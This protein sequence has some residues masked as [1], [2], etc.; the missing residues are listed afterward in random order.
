MKRSRV[1]VAALVVLGLGACACAGGLRHR[2]AQRS[3]AS[4]P[5][6]A[7]S[8]AVTSLGVSLPVVSSPYDDP[9]LA[10]ARAKERARDY[11]GALAIVSAARKANPADPRAACAFAYLEGRLAV[12]AEHHDAALAAFDAVIAG[13]VPTDGGRSSCGLAAYARLR[14]AQSAAKLG[15]WDVVLDRLSKVPEDFPLASERLVGEAEARAAKGDRAGAAALWRRMLAA[16]SFGPRWVDTSAKLAT[17]LLDGVLGDPKAEAKEAYELATRIVVSAPKFDAAQGATALRARAAALLQNA[18]FSAA[19]TVEESAKQVQSWLDAGEATRAA[20]AANEA[21]AKVPAPVPCKLALVRA[22]AIARTKQSS[23]AAWGEAITA[24]DGQPEQA[25]AF[26]GGGKA[27]SGKRPDEARARFAK[28]E[29]RFPKNRLADDARLFGAV[30]ARDAGDVERFASMLLAL[31]DDYPDGDMRAEAL[32]KVALERLRTG[33]ARGAVA[34]LERTLTLGL[35][36]RHASVARATYFL[37]RARAELGDVAGARERYVTVVREQPLSFFMLLAY[38]RLAEVNADDAARVL[39]EAMTQGRDEPRRTARDLDEGGMARAARLMEVGEID[40]A[41][42]EVARAGLK[43][44]GELSALVGQLFEKVGAFDAGVALAR[45]ADLLS[46][47]PNE[48]WRS[49]WEAAYPRAHE[50]L[51]RPEAAKNGI[52]VSLAWGIMR[53]ESAFAVEVK[54]SANAYGLMQLIVPTAKLVA[55]G[56]GLPFD[57]AGLKRADVNVTLGTKLLGQL[58]VSLGDARVLAP[59]AYNAGAGALGRW[60]DARKGEPFDLFVEEIPYEETRNY[61][62]KVLSSQAVYAMLYDRS[63]LEETLRLPAKAP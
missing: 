25:T 3:A 37:G 56:T 22:Q 21:V 33:D 15:Q 39:E 6:P 18:S 40:V 7:M 5:P 12:L 20:Q 55:Q 19:L 63:E 60:R 16:D 57:E 28:L 8:A 46:R 11:D 54:S 49:A 51:V 61:V 31:P 48:R 26:Y 36:P 4:G 53:E 29:E 14:A 52:P 1:V 2:A 47:Y 62:K 30:L 44:G 17:A 24:C 45:K 34:P 59:A 38:A 13:D 50:D 27:A 41:K 42:K 10:G 32:F 23:D 35:A 9:A 58:R 43:E